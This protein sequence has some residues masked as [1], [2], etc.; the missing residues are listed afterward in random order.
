M[1]IEKDQLNLN[2]FV[3]E[4]SKRNKNVI[5]SSPRENKLEFKQLC[6]FMF[7]KGYEGTITK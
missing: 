4:N 6:Y 2:F 3:F 7:E 1:I 5:P